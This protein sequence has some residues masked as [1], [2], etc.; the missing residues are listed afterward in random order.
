VVFF[1]KQNKRAKSLLGKEFQA[2][3]TKKLGSQA[4]ENCYKK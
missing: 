1:R 3:K 4:K 2:E